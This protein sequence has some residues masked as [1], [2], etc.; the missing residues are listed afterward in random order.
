MHKSDTMGKYIT[1][2]DSDLNDPKWK[3]IQVDNSLA[4]S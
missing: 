4:S 3:T 1:V 2:L